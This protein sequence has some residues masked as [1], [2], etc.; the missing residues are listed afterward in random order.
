MAT[1]QELLAQAQAAKEKLKDQ[2]KDTGGDFKYEVPAD[3]PCVC[4]LIS[5]LSLIHI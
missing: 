3:G 1:A 4:R 2:S 5:Y